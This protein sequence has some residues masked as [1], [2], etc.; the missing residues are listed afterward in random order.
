MIEEINVT[1]AII[2]V[3]PEHDAAIVSLAEEARKLLDFARLRTITTDADLRPATDDLSLIAKLKKAL[4]EKKAEYL[5][6]IKSHID[7]VNTAFA[8]IMQPLEEADS[9]TR[10][11]VRDYQAQVEKRH[12]EAEEINRQKAELA[13]REAA[14][15]GT[16]EITVDTKPV[17]APLPVGRVSSDFGSIGI[18]KV[19]KW[20]VEDITKV[21]FEYLIVDAGKIGKLVRAG[22]PSIPG[23]RIWKE[24][25]LRV[26]AR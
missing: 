10:N 24:G 2:K 21:P 26:T 14:F 18:A 13:Q 4:A 23:I 19:M 8:L 1:T 25:S 6:P 12:Q 11:K 7:A 20:E 9:I 16:G 22:I 5:K 17:E 15:N 3:G